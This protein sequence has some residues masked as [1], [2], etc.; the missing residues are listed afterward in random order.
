ML[1]FVLCH[2]ELWYMAKKGCEWFD[3]KRQTSI[4]ISVVVTAAKYLQ[5]LLLISIA[6]ASPS[7]FN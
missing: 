5:I 2:M 7:K 3:R 4:C 6:S 1:S